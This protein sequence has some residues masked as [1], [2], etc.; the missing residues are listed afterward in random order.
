MG[1]SFRA[2]RIV[3]HY[4]GA[5]LRIQGGL[6]LHDQYRPRRQPIMTDATNLAQE[7][8][9]SA[10]RLHWRSRRGLRELDLLFL[11]FVEEIYA[12]LPRAEQLAYQRLLA[13]EDT[14]LLLWM[15]GRAAPLDPEL[16]AI[17]GAIRTHAGAI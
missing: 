17:V 4:C 8:A 12:T 7:D 13:E 10:A 6:G 15:T 16:G 9:R 1:G 11:P 14:D 2:E 5:R 3:R